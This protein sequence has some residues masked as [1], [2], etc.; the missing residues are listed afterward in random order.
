MTVLTVS[1]IVL[2][3][4]LFMF[5]NFLCCHMPSYMLLHLQTYF[6]RDHGICLW[7]INIV[8]HSVRQLT[9]SVT[10]F[11][12]LVHTKEYIYFFI[13]RSDLRLNIVLL[14]CLNK[15]MSNKTKKVHIYYQKL[16]HFVRP[17]IAL[18]LYFFYI[19][20]T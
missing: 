9:Y 7:H 18:Y 3:S 4:V 10:V 8:Q 6:L 13:K 5:G 11:Q 16:I 2:C 15:E 14:T 1:C 20:F 19:L 12:Y 17:L